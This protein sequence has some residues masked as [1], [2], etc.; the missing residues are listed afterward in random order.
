MNHQ[1]LLG[2][3]I[4]ELKK[5]SNESIHLTVTSPPYDNLRDYKDK[6]LPPVDYIILAK[7]LYRLTVEGGIVAV[8]IQ[9]AVKDFAQSLSSFRLVMAFDEVGF[10]LFQHCIYHRNGRPGRFVRFRQDFENIFIF[11]KG[12]RPRIVN[13][14][15]LNIPIKNPGVKYS[16]SS[17]R[18]ADGSLKKYSF[19]AGEMKCRGTV[20]EYNNSSNESVSSE[21]RAIKRQHPATFPDKLVLDLI[22]CF[23]KLGETVLDPYVGSGT[24]SACAKMLGRNSIGIEI[25]E[26]YLNLSR[27]RLEFT[28]PRAQLLP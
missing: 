28:L 23:S 4:S 2:D 21:I 11:F 19:V 24:T 18:E 13:K 10:K 6:S 7:E 5:I 22:E 9:D 3:A 15:P 14:T 20:W 26:E 27:Q 16:K 8:I 12:K 17:S 25:F 1:L